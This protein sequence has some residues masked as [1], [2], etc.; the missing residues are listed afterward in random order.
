MPI[1]ST[2]QHE[3][4]ETGKAMANPKLTVKQGKPSKPGEKVDT[5]KAK[6]VGPVQEAAAK[7]AQESA[8]K[9]AA[10][11]AGHL[12]K[13]ERELLRDEDEAA[14]SIA[15]DDK[16][17]EEAV[18]SMNDDREAKEKGHIPPKGKAKAA[19]KKAAKKGSST[20]GTPV[21]R[22]TEDW[23]SKTGKSI[24]VGDTVKDLSGIVGQVKGRWSK[25]VADGS[26][27]PMVTIIITTLPTGKGVAT[28]KKVGAR[29]NSPS[30]FLV[31][32]KK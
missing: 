10:I 16:D 1:T 21:A 31:H 11:K 6:P 26:V 5:S 23:K 22:I 4:T 32:T 24:G 30:A 2:A 19:G 14:A 7:M 8:A 12:T 13:K 9:T 29:H 28:T 27:V 18:L 3:L 25:H 17:R 20:K 15:R